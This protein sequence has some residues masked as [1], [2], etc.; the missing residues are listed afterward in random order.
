MT[1]KNT[2]QPIKSINKQ[3]TNNELYNYISLGVILIIIIFFICKEKFTNRPNKIQEPFLYDSRTR[4]ERAR[5]LYILNKEIL[6]ANSRGILYANHINRKFIKDQDLHKKGGKQ[7]DIKSYNNYYNNLELL[8]NKTI[9]TYDTYFEKLENFYTFGKTL[10]DEELVLFN[11]NKSD[12]KGSIPKYTIKTVFNNL[13]EMTDKGT[14]IIVNELNKI[15]TNIKTKE[16]FIID[17]SV[18]TDENLLFNTSFFA[19]VKLSDPQI[20]YNV[21]IKSGS[22]VIFKIIIIS[23]SEYTK[24]DINSIRNYYS[25]TT[26]IKITPEEVWKYILDTEVNADNNLSDDIILSVEGLEVPVDKKFKAKNFIEEINKYIG[27]EKNDIINELKETYGLYDSDEKLITSRLIK[28][29]K[30][31]KYYKDEKEK[32]KTEYIEKL[33]NMIINQ[34]ENINDVDL[35]TFDSYMENIKENASKLLSYTQLRVYKKT[36]DKIYSEYSVIKKIYSDL[37]SKLETKY[38]N[39]KDTIIKNQYKIDSKNAFRVLGNNKTDYFQDGIIDVGVF[40]FNR[41]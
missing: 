10:K 2:K 28:F 13:N 20:R 27:N 19:K 7:D 36:K 18:S 35:I 16:T 21:L 33:D 12:F 31:G 41:D 37:I 29:D 4:H 22:T 6:T 25:P 32:I 34:F 9:P 39:F 23:D 15:N 3:I 30:Y 38:R 11:I 26:H 1:K 8:V 5:E 24:L 40:E 14:L 17:K